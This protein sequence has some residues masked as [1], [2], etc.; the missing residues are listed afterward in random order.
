MRS[1][2]VDTVLVSL[3]HYRSCP[4]G[5]GL[6]VSGSGKRT[7]RVLTD[8]QLDPRKMRLS[9]QGTSRTS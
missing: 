8:V 5:T 6:S 7:R 3:D 9:P 4:S 1:E 2:W